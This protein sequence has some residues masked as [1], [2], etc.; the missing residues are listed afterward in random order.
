[1]SALSLP[2]FLITNNFEAPAAEYVID[3]NVLLFPHIREPYT[4]NT[5]TYLSMLLSTGEERAEDILAFVESSVLPQIPETLGTL[6]AFTLMLPTQFD[7]HKGLFQTKFDEL[8]GPRVVGRAFTIEQMKHAKT[9]IPSDTEGFIS[10]G[11]SNTDYGKEHN[12]ITIPLPKRCG[13]AAMMAIGYVVIGAIQ[14][15][16]HAF[17]KEHIEAYCAFASQVFGQTINPIVE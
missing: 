10:F 1:M 14:R 17:F 8:F 6:D 5:S 3:E 11:V 16:H 12:R 15:Q 7:T 9:V 2:L 4:Y 13:P